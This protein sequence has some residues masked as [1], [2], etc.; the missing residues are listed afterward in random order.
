MDGGTK[1]SIGGAPARRPLRGTRS[2]G[3]ADTIASAEL[4]VP[5]S[6]ACARPSDVGVAISNA[7]SATENR[8][9]LQNSVKS[10][11]ESGERA[12]A[13]A[14]LRHTGRR[15]RAGLLACWKFGG[16][17]RLDARISRANTQVGMH[18][19]QKYTSL[20]G[21]PRTFFRPLRASGKRVLPY[22]NRLANTV[23]NAAI[24]ADMQFVRSGSPAGHLR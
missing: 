24:P 18:R 10:C 20:V 14:R 21:R 13:S 12:S 17:R 22:F 5:L 9:R 7:Q 3:L 19:D 6:R 4:L 23:L 1:A 15:A 11:G 16:G 8:Q 2:H